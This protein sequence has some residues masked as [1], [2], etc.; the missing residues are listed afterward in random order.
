MAAMSP[1]PRL[2]ADHR[3][4]LAHPGHSA[5][6]A[7]SRW[8]RP[9]GKGQ[10]VS[11]PHANLRPPGQAWASCRGVADDSRQ[12]QAGRSLPGLSGRPGRWPALHRRCAGPR[13]RGR[14]LAARAR[15]CLGHRRLTEHLPVPALRPLAGPL[16][17]AGLWPPERSL[18]LIAITGTNGKTTISQCLARAYPKPCAIIGTLGAGFPDA[19][20][21]TGF[22][23][24]EATTLMRYLADS[25]PGARPAR[26]KPVRSASRKGA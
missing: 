6:C 22:T 10:A 19:L 25:A 8:P 7:D 13:C 21:E 1:A 11:T 26:W 24:P 18:S 14:A 5:G 15:F 17:H 3:R 16:A 4:C 20:I 12:V 23:T 9:R 2:L